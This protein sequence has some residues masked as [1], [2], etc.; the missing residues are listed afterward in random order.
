MGAIRL[1]RLT[2]ADD[3]R[4]IYAPIV[5]DTA[6]SFEY[7][8]PNVAEMEA[9]LAMVLASKPWLVYED[10]RVLGYAYA[11]TFRE[12]AAYNWTVEVSIYVDS[13]AHGRGIGRQLY[14]T[15]FDVLRA[16]GYHLVIAGA[17]LPNEA[18]ERLHLGMGFREIARY[19]G[20]GYKFGK[21]H[22]TVFWALPLGPAPAV[23]P[24][25][26]NINDLVKTSEWAWLT[27]E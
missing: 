25:L 7:E 2:D 6:I 1:A 14:A 9:R 26:I 11:T 13:S 27:S 20:V 3:I 12:R 15:L 16:C 21:W 19:P 17:T 10:G 8:V 4:S 23:A 5:R 18:S 22:D 24:A